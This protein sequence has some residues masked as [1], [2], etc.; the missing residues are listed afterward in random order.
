MDISFNSSDSVASPP[1]PSTVPLPS[2]T[3]GPTAGEKV[4]RE[5]ASIP[6]AYG[7]ARPETATQPMLDAASEFHAQP[8]SV[9]LCHLF[10]KSFMGDRAIAGRVFAKHT[11]NLGSSHMAP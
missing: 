11:T 8:T 2:H 6:P 5:E 1:S 4:E 9:V 7:P 10:R 3:L